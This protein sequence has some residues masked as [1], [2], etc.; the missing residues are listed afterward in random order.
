[1][2]QM[3]PPL[4]NRQ[5]LT[6]V[7]Y[8]ALIENAGDDLVDR[9]PSVVNSF[10]EIKLPKVEASVKVEAPIKVETSV[11][12]EAPIKVEAF[13]VHSRLA[14]TKYR[15][16]K[17]KHEATGSR[18]CGYLFKLHGYVVK[19]ENAWKLAILN[20]VHNH[21]MLPYLA[22]HL[23][24][25]ILMEDDKAIVCDLTNSSVKPK[26]ILTNLK[27]KRQESMTNIKQV[28]NERHKFKKEKMG[29]LTKMKFLLKSYMQVKA[30]R[31]WLKKGIQTAL[32]VSTSVNVS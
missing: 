32:S 8:K 28:Y 20:G 2:S 14:S 27:K 21:K 17:L 4:S 13:S 26:N 10:V 30:N 29:D 3:L 23:L 7:E 16:K 18:K 5:Q 22:G 31:K 24:A 19:E 6:T 1:M 9:K 15:R 25:G 11:K 12:V